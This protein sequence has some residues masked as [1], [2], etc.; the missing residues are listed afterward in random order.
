[1]TSKL[2]LEPDLLTELLILNGIL[3]KNQPSGHETLLCDSS[4]FLS[5]MGNL[6]TVL[7]S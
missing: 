1:M 2:D 5:F 3:K 7:K 4:V 6:T